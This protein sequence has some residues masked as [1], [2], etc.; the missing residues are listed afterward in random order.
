MSQCRHNHLVYGQPSSLLLM[1]H[2]FPSRLIFHD[3]T[4]MT[5]P[6]QV[7]AFQVLLL[8]RDADTAYAP[9]AALKPFMPFRDASCGASCFHLQVQVRG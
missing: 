4:L 3:S 7:G 1:T 9:L 5:H 6:P 8:G 2:P